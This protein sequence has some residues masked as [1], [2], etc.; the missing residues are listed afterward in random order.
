MT[1]IPDVNMMYAN[2]IEKGKKE[3]QGKMYL[4]FAID[5]Q[6]RIHLIFKA[7]E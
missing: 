1:C 6:F 2:E 7:S 4:L 3:K 5:A